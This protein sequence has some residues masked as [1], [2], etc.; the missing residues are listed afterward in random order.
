MIIQIL[1][2]DLSAI[3]FENTYSTELHRPKSKVTRVLLI[4]VSH[5]FIV[6]S[7]NT[8]EIRMILYFA[9]FQYNT[10]VF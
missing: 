1:S 10:C 4:D 7:R 3:V 5:I 2:V 6:S 9:R 8:R